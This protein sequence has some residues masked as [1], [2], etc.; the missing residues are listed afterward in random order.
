MTSLLYAVDVL[1][2]EVGGIQDISLHF[3]EENPTNYEE[4]L[5]EKMTEVIVKPASMAD[6]A[7]MAAYQ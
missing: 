5:Q 6:Y 1:K 3:D 7:G 2:E 4:I